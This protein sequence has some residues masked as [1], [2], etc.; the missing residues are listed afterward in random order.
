MSQTLNNS[1]A[2]SIEGITSNCNTL[3]GLNYVRGIMMAAVEGA[4][5]TPRNSHEWVT[6]SMAINAQP[7]RSI[8]E[9]L[10]YVFFINI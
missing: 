8:D 10:L 5:L 6:M 3:G 1:N 4:R 7:T 2:C 9:D